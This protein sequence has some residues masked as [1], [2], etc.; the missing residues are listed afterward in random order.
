MGLF[1]S[2]TAWL[3]FSFLCCEGFG[4]QPLKEQPKVLPNSCQGL[5]SLPT[6]FSR[7]RDQFLGW[8]SQKAIPGDAKHPHFPGDVAE[9]EKV[10]LADLGA[11]NINQT[12]R[13]DQGNQVSFCF[14]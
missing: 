9:S 7:N 2:V 3:C 5:R 4:Q 14:P 12:F 11:P 6:D 10:N 8:A 13:L 1:V